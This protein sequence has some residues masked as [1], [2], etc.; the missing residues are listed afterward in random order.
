MVTGDTLEPVRCIG[1]DWSLWS[2]HLTI[3]VVDTMA[4]AYRRHSWVTVVNTFSWNIRL[5][6]LRV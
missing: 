3:T 6:P 4:G 2:G 1:E 5:F